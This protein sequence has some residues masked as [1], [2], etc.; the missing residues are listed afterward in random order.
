MLSSAKKLLLVNILYSSIV[1]SMSVLVPLYLIERNI[2]LGSVGLI[3]SIMPLVFLFVRL[4]FASIADEL[5]TK[6]IGVLYSLANLFSIALFALTASPL[7]FSL[8]TFAE[9]VRA[10]GFW[11]ITRTEILLE[12]GK[13]AGRKAFAFFSGV[14]QLADG[15]G[16]VFIG[17]A[18]AYFAFQGSFLLLFSLSILLL[19]LVFFLKDGHMQLKVDTKT[20]QRIFKKRPAS[21]WF[22][23]LGLSLLWLPS[24]M[25]PSFLLPIYAH[26]E[27]GLNYVETGSIAALFSLV[28]GA[29][30]LISM[31]WNIPIKLLFLF[32]A[33]MIPLLILLPFLGS[34]LFFVIL[35]IALGNGCSNILSEYVLADSVSKDGDLSTAIGL[36][37]VPLRI[38]E[39]LFLSLG[40]FAIAQFG[41][42]PLFYFCALL[43]FLS[44]VFVRTKLKL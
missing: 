43:V 18:L 14:R 32:T 33:L 31:K 28:S 23:G 40:G 15:I 27:L 35:L 4:V 17:F 11:A 26:A 24:N 36:T 7:G 34:N 3:L 42:A 20:V 6:V 29:A 9:G 22:T 5:G 41:Y 8:A 10:S 39:F 16:R 30:I 37:N 21:F 12:T 25:L 1:A 2:D 44:V 19:L 38:G 13:E